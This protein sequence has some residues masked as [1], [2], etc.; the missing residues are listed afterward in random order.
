MKN[1]MDWLAEATGVAIAALI[2]ASIVIGVIAIRIGVWVVIIAGVIYV[3][4]WH[5]GW[6]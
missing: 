6:F 2:A 3:L 5:F 4:N 1:W